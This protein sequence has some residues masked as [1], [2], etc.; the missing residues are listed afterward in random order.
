M[1]FRVSH[2]EL[3]S[4]GR[5]AALGGLLCSDLDG[6]VVDHGFVT[7]EE[8]LHFNNELTTARE[9]GNAGTLRDT[10]ISN[11]F[12]TQ[13]QLERIRKALALRLSKPE[14]LKALFEKM[15]AKSTD[16]GFTVHKFRKLL[17][18]GLQF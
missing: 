15:L 8:L 6:L 11:H 2:V 13:R 18:M 7:D 4:V 5:D 10:L 14:I 16:D 1:R 3:V 12:V 17:K 9:E